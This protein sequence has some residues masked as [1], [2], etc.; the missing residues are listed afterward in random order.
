[1]DLLA[2][3]EKSMFLPAVPTM[4]NA[5][6]NHPGAAEMDLP[7]KID[8]LNSGGGPIPVELIDQ[9]DDL[10]IVYTEGWGMRETTSLGIGNPVMGLKK[11]GSRGAFSRRGCKFT[12][13]FIKTEKTGGAGASRARRAER[14]A[15]VGRPS[16]GPACRRSLFNRLDRQA[17]GRNG[18]RDAG[19]M[20]QGK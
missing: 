15:R 1:M 8:M 16:R 6:V 19:P 11:F 2:G 12:A 10:G 14:R 18:R 9:V 7:K 4:I 20:D 17:H 3:I 5:I 13:L